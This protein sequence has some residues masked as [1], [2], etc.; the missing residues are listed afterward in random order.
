MAMRPTLQALAE[1]QQELNALR[2]TVGAQA[3]Q[4]TR[5]ASQLAAQGTT[6]ERLGRGLFSLASMA[7]GDVQSKIASAML[8]RADVQNPAQPVPEPPAGPPTES[9]QEAETPEAFAN[10]QDPGLVPGSTNDVA[11][12][13]TTTS[14]TPGMDIASQPFHQLIDVTQPVDGTQNPRPLQETKTLTDV[15]VGDPMNPQTAFPLGGEFANAQRTSS[16][17][18]AADA[19]RRTMASLRLARLRLQAGTAEGESDFVVAA[20][21]EKDAQV[22]TAAIE[23]EISTLENV[24]KAASSRAANARLVPK[25]ANRQPRPSLQGGTSHTASAAPVSTETEDADLFD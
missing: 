14:Y 16:K 10:V 4:L 12:D 21:I 11:A 19:S 5:Q 23:Q 18:A 17:T 8:K 1:Q 25:S 6:I 3:A 22:S 20:M 15:R 13:A 2:N 24:K 9:T 7:G